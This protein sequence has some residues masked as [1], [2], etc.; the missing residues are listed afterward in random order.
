MVEM[1]AECEADH[2]RQCAEDDQEFVRQLQLVGQRL[3]AAG[4]AL[5]KKVLAQE[6]GVPLVRLSAFAIR[7]EIDEFIHAS[8][9]QQRRTREAE[10]LA[11]VKAAESAL[12]AQGE[13]ISLYRLSKMLGV[14]KRILLSYPRVAEVLNRYR[15][16]REALTGAHQRRREQHEAQLIATVSQVRQRFE[17]EGQYVS[18]RR[19]S[20]ELGVPRQQLRTLP[21]VRLLIQEIREE[22]EQHEEMQLLAAVTEAIQSLQRSN[23]E[24]TIR[25]IAGIVGKSAINLRRY[26]AVQTILHN[27]REKNVTIDLDEIYYHKVLNALV[28]L[29]KQGERVTPSAVAREVGTSV[30]TLRRYPRVRMALRD[31]AKRQREEQE[32]ELITAIMQAVPTLRECGIPLSKAAIARACGR[33]GFPSLNHMPRLQA[34]WEALKAESDRERCESRALREEEVTMR[35]QHA[36]EA[37]KHE[38]KEITKAAVVRQ[39]GL[40]ARQMFDNHHVK[41]IFQDLALEQE[42]ERR[43]REEQL[44]EEV[45]RAVAELRRQ[46]KSPTQ[47]AIGALVGMS[48]H[49]LRKY[50]QVKRIFVELKEHRPSRQ[51]REEALLAEVRRATALLKHQGQR[52]TQSAIAQLVGYSVDTL[53]NYPHVVELLRQSRTPKSGIVQ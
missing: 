24:I 10:L 15:P 47:S 40:R 7:A 2:Q 32:E 48:R 37:L 43:R 29:H 17:S 27:V 16:T 35:V 5:T 11:Q 49:V 6:M 45:L 42:E 46:G 50:P 52:P 31:I 38:G 44:A 30:V 12:E 20:R 33:T 3:A 34:I 41:V 25:A 28:T 19:V 53:K 13:R 23:S 51:E 18:D 14:H 9:E 8:R 26:P 36:I 21:G 22:Q 39:S 1:L 4:I